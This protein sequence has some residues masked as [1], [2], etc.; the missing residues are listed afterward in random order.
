M[1]KYVIDYSTGKSR[2]KFCDPKGRAAPALKRKKTEAVYTEFTLKRDPTFKA[3]PE[4][5][6]WVKDL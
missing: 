2:P 6:Q 5:E 3:P 1:S 4:E